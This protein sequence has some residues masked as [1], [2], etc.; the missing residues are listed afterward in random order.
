MTSEE[1]KVILSI[2]GKIQTTQPKKKESYQQATQSKIKE[3]EQPVKL[4]SEIIE[5]DKWSEYA[6]IVK[7]Q[8]TKIVNI[9]E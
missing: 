8:P 6:G 5:T 1:E 7:K 9:E 3:P 2:S 4:K